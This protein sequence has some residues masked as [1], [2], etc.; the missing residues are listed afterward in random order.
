MGKAVNEEVVR[1]SE[2]TDKTVEE[3]EKDEDVSS[4]FVVSIGGVVLVSTLVRSVL[5][6]QLECIGVV[7]IVSLELGGGNETRCALFVVVIADIVGKSE[8]LEE[9][10]CNG[11]REVVVVSVV[12]LSSEARQGGLNVNENSLLHSHSFRLFM[13]L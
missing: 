10:K 1:E 8:V 13:E 3:F 4:L 2:E 6:L 9:V 11:G 12:V 5:E 7:E